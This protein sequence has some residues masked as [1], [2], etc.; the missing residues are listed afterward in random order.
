MI[1][2]IFARFPRPWLFALAGVIQIG[3]IAAL[4]V[5]RVEILRRGAEVKLQTRPVDPR[6][7]LRGDYVALSY[8]ISTVP[9][10]DL[11]DKPGARAG[12]PVFVTLAPA[13]DGFYQAVSVHLQPVVVTGQDVLIRG[14]TGYG[15]VCGGAVPVFCASI[16]VIYGLEKYFVPEGEGRTIEAATPRAV[17]IV[18]AI[19]PDGRAAIKRLL[20]DGKPVYDEPWF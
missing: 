10:G 4:V 5:Q 8:D 7:L 1:G 17:A 16:P 20:L 15:S 6:D 11:A 14:R 2:R 13:G 9:A 3:L 12:M 19:M 18:A